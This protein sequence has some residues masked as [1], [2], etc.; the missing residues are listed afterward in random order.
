MGILERVPACATTGVGSLPFADAGVA[1]D[2]VRSAY[3][4]PF[5][6]Q[7]PRLD[8]DMVSEWLGADPCRCGWSA[9]RD[10]ER[11]HA[12]E[13]FLGS[14]RSDPP[15]HGV[16]KLQVTGPLTLAAALEGRGSAGGVAQPDAGLVREMAAWIAA[17]AAGQ[18][19]ALAQVGVDAV[20]QVDEPSLAAV[21]PGVELALDAW[22]PVRAVA[23]AW[24]LHVC[25]EVPWGLVEEAQP[26]LVSFDATAAGAVDRAAGPL[27]GLIEREARVTWGVLTPGGSDGVAEGAAAL[28]AGLAALK[29]GVDASVVLNASFVTGTCGTGVATPERERRIGTALDVTAAAGRARAGSRVLD[30]TEALA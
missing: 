8:G 15:A 24:G 17:S 9:E 29:P 2:W 26:D 28:A 19:R 27:E 1:V 14:M 5:C 3:E 11:P 18:V 30:T 13:A 10:R 21:A 6:P 16:A 7:L 4:V 23:A 20:V 25:C 22:G 12:W